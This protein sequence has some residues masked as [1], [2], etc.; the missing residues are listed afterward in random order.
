MGR[1]L[2]A[3]VV[4]ASL[5][6]LVAEACYWLGLE[7][8]TLVSAV[9]VPVGGVLGFATGP[10]VI[11]SGRPV[12]LALGLAVGAVPVGTGFFLTST[13][14]T[15]LLQGSEPDPQPLYAV[16]V[17]SF[18]IL[19]A[20]FVYGIPLTVPT[21]LVAVGLVRRLAQLPTRTATVLLLLLATGAAGLG[22]VTVAHAQEATGPYVFGIRRIQLDGPVSLA[23][24][25]VRLEWTVV[26]RSS[27]DLL[28]DVRVPMSDGEIGTLAELPAC[29]MSAGRYALGP[30][31]SLRLVA[32]DPENVSG[33]RA[34][35]RSLVT[36]S[37]ATGTDPKVWIDVDDRLSMMVTL[38]RG[39]PLEDEL[40]RELC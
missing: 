30:S 29:R 9:G 34:R 19:G 37:S 4:G 12:L 6:A 7:T 27:I 24:A 18:A 2:T 15:G 39:M 33:G 20:A 25:A 32:D 10:R 1:R 31:W 17:L 22:A 14:V 36:G 21:A 11:A 16:I 23:L 8:L 28:M 3:A 35:G 13:V 5:S 38:G 26:N 40:Q